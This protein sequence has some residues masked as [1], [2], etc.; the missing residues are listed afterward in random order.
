MNLRQLE[1]LL[2]VVEHGSF[3][4]A[5]RESLL[6]QSTVSQHIAAL[7]REFGLQLLERSR[8]GIRVTDGGRIVLKHARSVVGE[9]RATRAAVARFRGLE[10]TTLRLGVSTIPG[11]YL[12]PAVLTHLCDRFPGLDVLVLQGDSRETADRIAS[13]EVE[14]G[15]VGSRFEERG[16]VYVAVGREVICL[17][18]SGGHPWAGRPS[19]TVE[20]LVTGVF[21]TR[22][23][24]SGTGKTVAEAL[25]QAGVE[26]D[27][28]R[29]RAQLGGNEAI[30]A[31]VM[32]G[33]GTA[34]LS[35]MAVRRDVERGDLV[36]VPVDGL[37]ITR[38]FYLVRRAGRE[39]SPAASEFWTLMLTTHGAPTT[40]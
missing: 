19:I 13:R 7:E 17:V 16:F 18:A 37:N 30:R 33:L 27:R 20:E 28:L 35:E 29:V 8:N 39:L 38:P 23:P 36:V 22:E 14:A 2:S 26:A 40:S 3:S 25:R 5:A 31:A 21:V 32:S 11:G 9:V 12:V 24:G 1:V 34:F 10:D 15:V 6:T 4:A